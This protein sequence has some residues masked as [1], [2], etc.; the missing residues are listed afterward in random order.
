MNVY[1]FDKT[2]FY[3]DSVELFTRWEIKRHPLNVYQD[4]LEIL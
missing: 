2:L 4:Y 1:D 3:T